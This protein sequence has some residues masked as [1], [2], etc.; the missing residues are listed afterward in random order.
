MGLRGA[1]ESVMA[2]AGSQSKTVGRGAARPGR[3]GCHSGMVE[4]LV[5][6]NK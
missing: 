3:H 2:L 1:W 4:I 6:L 5:I